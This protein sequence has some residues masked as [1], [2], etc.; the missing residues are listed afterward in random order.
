MQAAGQRAK[1]NISKDEKKKKRGIM[2]TG[3]AGNSGG[4]EIDIKV[5]P[6]VASRVGAPRTPDVDVHLPRA[7]LRAQAWKAAQKAASGGA[8]PADA[9]APAASGKGDKGKFGGG[10]AAAACAAAAK[11]ALKAVDGHGGKKENVVKGFVGNL[12]KGGGGAAGGRGSAASGAAP[13]GDWHCPR[14]KIVVF[15][16]KTQCFLCHT[17]KTDFTAAQLAA[18]AAASGDAAKQ[19]GKD[20]KAPEAGPLAAVTTTRSTTKNPRTLL[21]EFCQKNKLP[22]VGINARPEKAKPPPVAAAAAD[23]EEFADDTP[24]WERYKEEPVEEGEVAGFRGKAIQHSADKDGKATVRF[25]KNLYATAEEAQQAAA[26]LGLFLVAG[27]RRMDRVLTSEFVPLWK[28]AEED[29]AQRKK[30]EAEREKWR[31]EREAREAKMKKRDEALTQLYLSDAL[32]RML[33]QALRT[34]HAPPAAEY[35]GDATPVL[36]ELQKLGWN[37]EQAR[38]GV[39]FGGGSVDAA[40][41][42]LCLCE[43]EERLPEKFRA[44][45]GAMPFQVVRSTA[46]DAKADAD[47]NEAAAGGGVGA[48]GKGRQRAGDKA[49]SIGSESKAGPG[50][51]GGQVSAAGPEVLVAM[52]YEWPE[53]L[54]AVKASGGRLQEAACALAWRAGAWEEGGGAGGGFSEDALEEKEALEAIYG[55]GAFSIEKNV[56]TVVVDGV[57]DLKVRVEGIGKREREGLRV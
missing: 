25:T 39:R 26:V 52:G 28:E 12:A 49:G 41:D 33:A 50:Q 44:H 15:A 30:K 55:D 42:H 8:G 36:D 6:P 10:D 40:V 57:A 48:A 29:E 11:Q 34:Y 47:G 35:L 24:W 31:Q 32:F 5:C 19:S 2:S 54:E 37:S 23:T 51:A 22:K 18:A 13:G 17:A 1:L 53:V 45:G 38:T 56:W 14:C 46:A 43:P 16:S 3:A 21:N 27:D 4:P 9:P 20:K 7:A